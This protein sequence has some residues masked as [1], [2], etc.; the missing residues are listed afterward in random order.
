M[1][2]KLQEWLVPYCPSSI[3]VVVAVGARVVVKLAASKV[4]LIAGC[5]CKGLESHRS[6]LRTME[7][8]CG[9]AL[10]IELPCQSTKA[11]H[12]RWSDEEWFNHHGN[13]RKHA[14]HG[15]DALAAVGIAVFECERLGHE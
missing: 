15:I 13:A 6:V 8:R 2:H 7:E 5:S 1:H 11:V 14:R 3:E 10:A 9:V 4:L 12:R